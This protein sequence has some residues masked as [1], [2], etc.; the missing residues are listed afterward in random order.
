MRRLI[1][2]LAILALFLGLSSVTH[3]QSTA[4]RRTP[5]R[6]PHRIRPPSTPHRA[7]PPRRAAL[8]RAVALVAML[9]SLLFTGLPT[10]AQSETE[11]LIQVEV[12]LTVFDRFA[13][14]G[15]ST[16]VYVELS[17]DPKREVVIPITVT[18]RGGASAADYAGVP[19]SLT[20]RPEECDDEEDEMCYE[21]FS[22]FTFRPS[23]DAE[24]DGESV[25]FGFGTPLPEGVSVR[26]GKWGTLTLW[27]IDAAPVHVG[28]PQVGVGLV[29]DIYDDSGKFSNER[30]QW[31]RSATETGAYTDIPAAE[32]GT[33]NPYTPS[34]GDLGMWLKAKVTYDH[35]GNTGRTSQATADWPVLSQPALSNASYGNANLIGY[36]NPYPV[37]HRYAQAFTTG[38]HV[39]GYRL[40]SL[41]IAL[42][43]YGRSVAGTWGVHA[44]DAG[45]PAAAPLSA[46]LPI[47]SSDL[48]DPIDTFEEF[49]HPEVVL[50]QPNTKYWLVISQ[51]T[52]SEDGNIGIGTLDIR[53][54]DN[55]PTVEAA[56]SVYMCT[57]TVPP[58]DEDDE[59]VEEKYPCRPAADPGSEDGWTFE[60][61]A[62]AH[63]YD[64]P[65]DN[66]SPPDPN[67]PIYP[68]AS[69]YAA[70][71]ADY[72]AAI[73]LLPWDFLA[74]VMELPYGIVLRM[75]LVAPPVV[76]V[77]FGASSHTVDE[78]GSVSVAVEL[79]SDPKSTV[80]IPIEATG[81]DGATSADYSV[82]TS[83]TFKSG[84]TTKTI[85]FAATQ[86]TVDDDDESVKLSF[87]TMP[88]FGV[89]ADTTDETT[90]SITDDDDPFVTVQFEASAY[91][92]AESDDATTTGTAENEVEVTVTLSADPERTVIIPIEAAGQDG[93]T[94][95]DYSGVP[96]SVT[97][98]DGETEKSFTFTATHDT[99][100]DDDESVLLEF[101]TMP[102]A[103]V[104]AGATDQAIVTIDDDDA[105]FVTVQYGQDSQGVG[106]GETVNVT[107]S[108]SA[109]PERTVTIPVTS[110]PQGTA[111]AA[112]YT[113]PTS[114]TFNDGETEKT[115]AFMA[116]NDTEDDDDESVKLGFG[117]T[118]PDRVSAGTRTE[119][120]LNIGDDDDPTVTVMFGASTYTVAESDDATTSNMTENEVVVTVTLSADPER[121]III[122]ITRTLQGTAGAADYS[123]PPSVTFDSGDTSK[124]LTFSATH[125]VIDDDGEGVKLGFGTMPDPR[126]SAGTPGETTVSI[127]DDD[128]AAIVLS[129]T[130]LAVG[131]EEGASYTVRL[132]TEP[133]V[134]VIVTLTGH[135]GT[136][137]TLR[138]VKLSN[139]KLTFTPDNWSIPQ[140][141]MVA[142]GH[143][144]NGVNDNESLTHTASGAEYANVQRALPVPVLDN[145]PPGI[146]IDPLALLVD[147]SDS[148]DYGVTL[149]TEPT[150]EVTVTVTGHAG[151][152]LSLSGP[153]LSNDALTFTAANWNTPQTV[154]VAAAHDDDR[155]DDSA[156]LTHTSSGGEY[157]GLARSLPV[158]VDDN[159]GDLR[160]VDGTKTDEDGNLCEGR[161]EIYWD[162]AWGT[163]CDDY[164][165]VEDADV[166]CRALGF[167]GG[168]VE[169]WGRF[170]TGYFP[171]GSVDQAIVLDDVHCSGSETNLLDCPSSQPRPGVHNCRHFEDVGLRCL[172]PGEA[173]PF[174]IEVEV[175]VP[176]GG[177]NLYDAGET[178]EVTLVWNEAVTISTP[179][180]GLRPKVWVE[181]DG[182][183]SELAVYSTGSGTNRTVFTHTVK[184]M[185][186]GTSFTSMG[187]M[188]NSLRE[189]DSS[190]RSSLS[191]LPAELGHRSYKLAQSAQQV[192]AVTITGVPTFN[193]AG[194]DGFFGAGETVEIAF[195]FSQPVQVDTT[196]GTP[197]VPV[198]LSGTASRQAVYLS[199]SGAGRLVFGYT[200]TDTDG[201]H[202]SLLVDPN[203][204]TLNGGAIR[205]TVNNLDVDIG[206][207]GGGVLFTRPADATA[208]QL[209]T[210]T[211]DGATLTLTYDEELDYSVTPSS[212]LFAVNVD[213]AARSVMGVAV[214]QSSVILLLSPAVEAG[215]TVT[216]DYTVPTEETAARLQDLASNAVA[217]FSGQ[218]VTNQTAASVERSD[219]VQAPTSLEVVVHE[220]GK[221]TASWDAPDS[222]PAAKWY[223]VQWK[224]SG[225]GWDD[226]DDVS[227]ANVKG[228]SHVI[229]GLT[230]GTEYTV[231]VMA[232]KDN[233]DSEPSDEVTATPQETVPPSP[234]AATVDG[235][236]VTIT[237]DEALD[238]GETPDNSAFSV[239]VAGSS[240]GVAAAA[241]SGTT[242]TLTLVTAVGASD[243]VTVSY[244]A[245]TGE[246]DA[247][248]QDLAGNAADSFSGQDVANDTQE[249]PQMTATVHDVPATHDGSSTF[250]FELRFSESPRNGF[251]YK[252]M[253]DHAFT[254][255]GG[256]V[257]KARR[258]AR[259]SNVGWEIT[260]T[261]D[262]NGAVTIVLPPT[263]DCTAEGAICTQDA[264]R[265]PARWR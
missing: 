88:H 164:W 120:T 261:P 28:L 94:T 176:P 203:S 208:P 189:R 80:T 169:D 177:N 93:A 49:T 5:N 259:P 87:G 79:S 30:W 186:S 104:S 134:D 175:S 216:V 249:A 181:Y 170:K 61:D 238:T 146:S 67:D 136:D 39:R 167:I 69:S 32:G 147:E 109:D 82:P 89:S 211:V 35:G 73:A 140:T 182:G 3:A 231:R 243:T 174:I 6:P 65:D 162:G 256:D 41:R 196:G 155:E 184:A 135:S 247:R 105:P 151:T 29:A 236:T 45:K 144:D 264:G 117:S 239:A 200:L 71:L 75:S 246:A 48:D 263:T 126:V 1:P 245:P 86:D 78:G 55:L 43:L 201:E 58:V 137:L 190:L 51:T 241:V 179:T 172:N 233:A 228:I 42:Y 226:T 209:Q 36:V 195:T 102:D 193:D 227:E 113:V 64:D 96:A 17:E 121:T 210:A 111:S 199:G 21:T 112:D 183:H 265:S 115:I 165:S 26:A 253:R 46:A 132:D 106:E 206:H 90:V 185:G 47:L 33:S 124:T 171:Q 180:D 258:L 161:L 192:E 57:R 50:L 53:F 153:T 59:P 18:N 198:L 202:S 145:D 8:L 40:T 221:L 251:S 85:T 237:F 66:R 91:T 98:N 7:K 230:D 56:N 116:V 240:R 150:V 158:T 260:V 19:S 141:V 129:T 254:V 95:A 103:R 20:F 224:E 197:S 114:V 52:P 234:S 168:T 92:V 12:Y 217:S 27:I 178:L 248:L 110:T 63:F 218:A 160:L 37:L 225:T 166:A 25:Q 123:V 156:T 84:E 229:T 173:P 22:G 83:V 125:D 54:S 68:D 2:I 118:L 188:P 152:D 223:T 159:S 257:I 38:S 4:P 214:G 235:A 205:D 76:T 242:V 72:N 127:T 148:A 62:L 204:L 207:Q 139:D 215:E 130:S 143:D 15:Q 131:E 149:D 31:Q 34:A 9:A 70:A 99:V 232:R 108:L 133:T 23:R 11:E 107:I 10:S 255:T 13:P 157:A 154:T 220:S 138:G 14:E 262:G 74:N 142:A 222:G 213:G 163:I 128:T 60:F 219:P 187:V 77:Q 194:E 212:G 24:D 252:L 101:G 97:F 44:D 16:T 244:T 191:D 119:T 122:P 250:T 81:E 100:D